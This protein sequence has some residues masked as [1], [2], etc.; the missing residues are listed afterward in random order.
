MISGNVPQHLVV[1]ARSGFLT[2]MQ[3]PNVSQWQR[4]AGVFNMDAKTNNVVSL[5]AAPMPI[6]STG[7][8]PLQD[9]VERS[10]SVKAREWDIVVGISYAAVR[11]DQTGTL[12]TEVRQ[13][14]ENFNRA[15]N[16][17]VFKAIDAGDAATYGLCYDGL[18]MFSASHVDKGAAYTSTQANLGALALSLDNFSTTF[19]LASVFVN[20][21]GEY[22]EHT[23][24]ILVVPPAL[25]QTAAQICENAEAYDTA[26]REK[27]PYA[28]IVNYLVRPQMNSTAWGLF[29]TN[30]VA[31]P[32]YMAIREQ[33]N[34]QD[35]WFDPLAADGGKYWFKFHAAYNVFYGD[36]RLGFLGN[37]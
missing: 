30:Q 12:E 25:R 7:R 23:Y 32:L 17:L 22:T 37:S 24:D 9:F 3:N 16:N 21:Q 5:G 10:L 15:M 6:E 20:D 31:K 27:N 26:N 13:A 29:A 18:N 8:G 36:W 11:D 33:P 1:G 35:A 4:V 34:L 14:G 2:A 28:G 19:N